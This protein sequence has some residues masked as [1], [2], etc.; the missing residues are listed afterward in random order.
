MSAVLLRP[1][2]AASYTRASLLPALTALRAPLAWLIVVFHFSGLQSFKDAIGDAVYHA[3]LSNGPF[4]VD[5]F[6]ILS[7]FILFHVHSELGAQFDG[8]KI[9]EFLTFRLARIYPLH[10]FML[11][12]FVVCIEGLAYAT[13]VKPNDA[14]RFS[15]YGF[16]QHV[17]LVQGW[18]TSLL[19]WNYP[20][21]SISSEWAAYLVA[22]GLF[23]MALRL[24][25]QKLVIAVF[26]TGLVLALMLS[27]TP[28]SL[29][30]SLPRVGLG[31]FLGVLV[32]RFRNQHEAE[33][34]AYRRACLTGL[35]IMFVML[36]LRNQG[37][38]MAM[39]FTGLVLFH[40]IQAPSRTATPG[41]LARVLIYLGQTSFAVYMGHAFIEAIW[42]T[43]SHKM[44]LI[45]HGGIVLQ[46]LVLVVL[47]Q[48]FAMFL[49]HGVEEPARKA[50]RHLAKAEKVAPV[51]LSSAPEI[52]LDGP[53]PFA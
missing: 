32:C 27:N 51:D 12:L 52:S 13:D 29:S 49:H 48:G 31:F 17:F 53:M 40:G 3:P 46:S 10:L 21:W 37:G 30:L 34:L 19:S 33:L 16:L 41:W 1:R 28:P 22:P 8:A 9:R 15:M 36:I 7:G 4:A 14:T 44:G 2:L 11:M 6:F 38:G 18:G 35:W 47:I 26:G 42:I 43:L 24:E 25:G 50:L 23:W 5:C 45:N 39:A 20:S